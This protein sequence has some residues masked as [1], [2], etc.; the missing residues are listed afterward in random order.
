MIILSCKL[1]VPE[2][3]RVSTKGPEHEQVPVLYL[4][5]HSMELSIKAYLL[6][7]GL[8][9]RELRRRYGHDLH[10]CMKKAKE[11][12]LLNMVK[13]D[14][15]EI[16]AFDAL[17]ELYSTKQLEYIV[18]GEKEFPITGSLYSASQKLLGAICPLVGFNR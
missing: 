15:G 4:I 10:K 8:T 14:D 7:N 2:R 12:G 16:T 17:A 13:L 11:L 3:I 18:T 5:G 1:P 9:L 6:Q